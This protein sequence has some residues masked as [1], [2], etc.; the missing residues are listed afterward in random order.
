MELILYSV[1]MALITFAFLYNISADVTRTG[2][3]YSVIIIVIM[4]II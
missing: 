2:L 1:Q 4:S 3:F